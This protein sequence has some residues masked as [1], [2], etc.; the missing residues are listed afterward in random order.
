MRLL[1]DI[2]LAGLAPF[3]DI[4]IPLVTAR[5]MARELGILEPLRNLLSWKTRAMASWFEGVDD[6]GSGVVAHKSVVL[7]RMMLLHMRPPGRS[8]LTL[9]A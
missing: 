4:W 7:A 8:L 1:A 6:G 2:T 3:P 5:Q 9:H